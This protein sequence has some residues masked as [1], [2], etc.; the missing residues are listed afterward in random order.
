MK[1]VIF[2]LLLISSLFVFGCNFGKPA[3]SDVQVDNK[4]KG[5][6][7][8]AE[9]G[10]NPNPE[11][12]ANS[13]VDP[14]AQAEKDAGLGNPPQQ[15]P[16]QQNK[17]MQL[18]SFF[19]SG[20]SEIKD[21]PKYKKSTIINVQYGPVNG[22]SSAML[23]FE[24]RD[25]VEKINEFYEKSIKSNG[26]EV[27]TNIKDPDNFEYTLSKGA[28]DEALIRIKKDPQSGHSV[29]LLSRSEKPAELKITAT[30]PTK[31]PEKKK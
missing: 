16:P 22:V 17:E 23:I 11:P 3:Y 4:T 6:T 14:I 13:S 21:L 2:V 31:V 12:S 5:E 25:S 26:W 30:P 15:N 29:I 20:Q 8:R 9:P 10:T 19:V 18:P 1:K 7:S 24:S 27:I 28:R